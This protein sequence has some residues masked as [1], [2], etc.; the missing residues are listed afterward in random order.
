ME[1]EI[2]GMDSLSLLVA[3]HPILGQRTILISLQALLSS[4]HSN[5]SLDADVAKHYTTSK[6]SFDET[7]RYW[8]RI[9][10][11]DPAVEKTEVE[12]PPI[13]EIVIAGLEEVHVNQLE[14]LGFE[15]SKVVCLGKALISGRNKQC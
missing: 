5:D 13:D 10:V 1:Q 6:Q 4:P 9:Y 15:R 12:E 8:T 11:G 2:A 3:H 7:A 14:E